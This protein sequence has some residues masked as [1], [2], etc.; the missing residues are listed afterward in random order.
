MEFHRLFIGLALP[1]EYQQ[2]LKS[3]TV[4]ARPHIHS[5]CSWTQPGDW[6]VTLKF[7]GDTPTITIPAIQAAL[8]EVAW[9]AFSFAA[10]GGG[11]FPS[12]ERP[13]V[14]WVGASLGGRETGAL[15]GAIEAALTAIGIPPEARPFSVH[16]T[17][18]RIR[19]AALREGRDRSGRTGY[20]VH[21]GPAG[22]AGRAAT[23]DD[24]PAVLREIGKIRWP[25]LRM[26]RFVLW[27]SLPFGGGAGEGAGRPGP[28]Y[29]PLGTYAAAG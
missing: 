24:W 18:A 4:A 7:L 1:E 2:A 17:L 5:K 9:E 29:V 12:P 10:G 23:G 25:E 28:R 8:A 22:Q 14:L 6:H 26:D 11:F 16:L 19:H 27:R 13:R 3:L 15:A 20:T 21:A